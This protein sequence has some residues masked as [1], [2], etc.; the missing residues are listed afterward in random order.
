LRLVLGHLIIHRVIT[1]RDWPEGH[2]ALR[3]HGRWLKVE[4]IHADGLPGVG[5]I[6]A[7]TCE[8]DFRK[9][10]DYVEEAAAE[11][12]E[13]PYAGLKSCDMEVWG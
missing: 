1:A 11:A 10:E 4:V 3:A 12:A 9:P 8:E 5:Y 2:A 7:L 6:H 13:D